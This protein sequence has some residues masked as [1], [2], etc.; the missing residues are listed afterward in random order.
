MSAVCRGADWSTNP[1]RSVG[2]AEG[3]AE[4]G[5]QQL[6]GAT[7]LGIFSRDVQEN[8]GKW[9][10]ALLFAGVEAQLETWGALHRRE[11]LVNPP[12]KNA[13]EEMML[14]TE[15]GKLWHYPIDNEAGLPPCESF[16]EHV[17]LEELIA[18]FPERGPIRHFME[19]VLVGLSKNPHIS[20]QRKRE[21]IHWFR[22]YF[23]NKA[24]VLE[25]SGLLPRDTLSSPQARGKR[26]PPYAIK[27]A[28]WCPLC[29]LRGTPCNL[30]CSVPRWDRL[31]PQ[32]KPGFL[33][34][35][36]WKCA[37]SVKEF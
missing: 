4:T 8:R 29:C 2:D 16:A 20:V 1:V 27:G 6:D 13:Y 31:L 23:R 30:C 25:A 9:C 37:G 11:L 18:D 35:G 22:E 7:R 34:G 10:L 19:L 26:R 15:Q 32:H 17:F 24:A 12:P 5:E 3:E 14:W 33:W 36:K 21:H 28:F